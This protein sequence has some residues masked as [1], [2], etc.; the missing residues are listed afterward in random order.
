[1]GICVAQNERAVNQRRLDLHRNVGNYQHPRLG[2]AFWILRICAIKVEDRIFL[3]TRRSIHEAMSCGC[4]LESVEEWQSINR[5]LRKTSKSYS[6]KVNL[7][8]DN[9][10]VG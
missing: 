7:P 4:S 6:E 9:P 10:A 3:P 5:A 1:V 2:W 8:A